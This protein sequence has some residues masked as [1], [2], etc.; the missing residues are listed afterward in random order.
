[1][2]CHLNWVSERGIIRVVRRYSELARAF[3][4][5]QPTDGRRWSQVCGKLTSESP[6]ILTR[7][8][9]SE[10]RFCDYAMPDCPNAKRT[11]ILPVPSDCMPYCTRCWCWCGFKLQRVTG[12]RVECSWKWVEVQCMEAEKWVETEGVRS[13]RR[14]SNGPYVHSLESCLWC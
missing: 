8:G 7:N 10:K 4:V 1:M 9:L 6:Y 5:R 3:P 14:I 13:W 12:K 2:T 11:R